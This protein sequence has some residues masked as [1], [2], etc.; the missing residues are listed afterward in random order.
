V[1]SAPLGA[2]QLSG[3]GGTG[4]ENATALTVGQMAT[5]LIGATAVRIAFGSSASVEAGTTDPILPA[6]GRFDWYVSTADCF[7][8][9]QA[10]DAS[11]AYEAHVWTSSGQRTATS[12]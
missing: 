3:T 7:V 1:G 9:V 12:G 11:S 2:Q 8:S 10:A 4:A 5:L 6:Y